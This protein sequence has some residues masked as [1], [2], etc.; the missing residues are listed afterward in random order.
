MGVSPIK[1]WGRALPAKAAAQGKSN[2]VVLSWAC[3]HSPEMA[4]VVGQVL[5]VSGG[6]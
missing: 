4:C 5:E 6:G 1:G 2:H 3:W